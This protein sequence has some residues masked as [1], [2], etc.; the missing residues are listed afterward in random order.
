MK[1]IKINKKIFYSKLSKEIIQII[2]KKKKLVNIF[3]TGGNSAEKIYNEICKNVKKIEIKSTVNI[4]QTDERIFEKRKNKNSENIELNF[5][6]KIN[7][8]KI[9]FFPMII[10]NTKLVNSSTYYNC[11]N[12]FKIDLILLTL[13]DDG[14]V[15]SLSKNDE[16]IFRDKILC[17][18][19]YN[20]KKINRVTIGTKFFNKAENIFIICNGKKK[21]EMYKIFKKKEKYFKRLNILLKRADFYFD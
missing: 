9:K 8:K 20:S 5:I 12:N 13:G 15:A 21:Q 4:Y 6:K 7:N 2:N 3:F 14:H 11:Y 10:N 16:N 18:T 19:K 17:F 1:K